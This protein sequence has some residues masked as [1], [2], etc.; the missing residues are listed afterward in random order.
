M[1]G[2]SSP[3]K[4][5]TPGW[6]NEIFKN[7]FGPSGAAWKEGGG[8]AAMGWGPWGDVSGGFG[9]A[10]PEAIFG[11]YSGMAG[12]MG[13][14]SQ[15]AAMFGGPAALNA[16]M[17]SQGFANQANPLAAM[18]GNT[19]ALSPQFMEATFPFYNQLQNLVG[20][21]GSYMDTLLKEGGSPFSGQ[22]AGA[23]L[24]EAQN[25]GP[26]GDI[27]KRTMDLLTPQVR[28]SFA[29][30][31]MGGSGAAIKEEG[32]QAQ[33]LADKMAQEAYQN[34]AA[35][36]G[37]GAQGEQANAAMTNALSSILGQRGNILQAGIQGALGGMQAPGQIFGQHMGA[38][39]QGLQ[40]LAAAQGAQLGPMQALGAGSQMMSGLTGPM[41]ALYGATREPYLQLL[42]AAAGASPLTAKGQYHSMLGIPK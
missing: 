17:A 36:M 6:A 11:P 27:Y 1:G 42:Q 8:Q 30:R 3:G 9:A 14:F 19:A 18:S 40:N 35:F 16:A 32:S 39:G 5:S 31:G 41:Q 20:K 29:A 28:S 13:D 38:F 21:T 2:T 22:V 12:P 15:Q 34:R 4:Q 26:S 7:I 25:V 33:Q 10:S 24:K 37:V 23:A